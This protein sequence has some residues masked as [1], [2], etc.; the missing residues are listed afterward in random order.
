MFMSDPQRA[1]AAAKLQLALDTTPNDSP[2]Y[3]ALAAE[4]TAFIQKLATEGHAIPKGF[5]DMLFIGLAKRGGDQNAVRT[6]LEALD[7]EYKDALNESRTKLVSAELALGKLGMFDRRDA[8][9]VIRALQWKAVT[10][11]TKVDTAEKVRAWLNTNI[12]KGARKDEAFAKV[13]SEYMNA[14]AAYE[15]KRMQSLQNVVTL[16]R[17]MMSED[18]KERAAEEAQLRVDV[19]RWFVS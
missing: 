6:R 1:E 10:D 17:R 4:R 12:V 15:A 7:R 13:I 9:K 16:R 14:Q 11:P 5:E 19:V 18:P 3:A 8:K 2:E